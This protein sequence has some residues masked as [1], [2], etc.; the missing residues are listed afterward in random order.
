[1]RKKHTHTHIQ[2]QTHTHVVFVIITYFQTGIGRDTP[3]IFS[4][5]QP[6]G[7]CI[8]ILKKQYSQRSP[9]HPIWNA[10]TN[11]RRLTECSYCR[12]VLLAFLRHRALAMPSRMTL[13]FSAWPPLSLPLSLSNAALH[14][15][16]TRPQ[17]ILL[18]DTLCSRPVTL[19]PCRQMG[20]VTDSIKNT[21]APLPK[22]S[23][24]RVFEAC[25]C[26]MAV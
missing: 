22:S 25:L 21:P 1:M 17:I 5:K 6:A 13:Q 9:L 18:F 4:S 23:S 19:T 20:N 24:G 8:S 12:S 2:A 3:D 10:V 15:P 26:C 16:S 7:R 11:L 14:V